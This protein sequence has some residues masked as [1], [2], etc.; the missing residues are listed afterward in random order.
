M[1]HGLIET[2]V[3]KSSMHYINVDILCRWRK[4]LLVKYMGYYAHINLVP[5]LIIQ[6]ILDTITL[7]GKYDMCV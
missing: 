7:R 6:K 5:G 4:M 2:E 1:S 3:V